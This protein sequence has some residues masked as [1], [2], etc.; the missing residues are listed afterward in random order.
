[1]ATTTLPVALCTVPINGVSIAAPI[2]EV[3]ITPE[4][5]PPCGPIS[6]NERL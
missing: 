4:A 6:S 1:M 3:D 5:T 2:T